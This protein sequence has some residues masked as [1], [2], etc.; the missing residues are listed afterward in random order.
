MGGPRVLEV[1]LRLDISEKRKLCGRIIISLW[2]FLWHLPSR[3]QDANWSAISFLFILRRMSYSTFTVAACDSLCVHKSR[4]FVASRSTDISGDSLARS[5]STSPSDIPR[6]TAS[7]WHSSMSTK[8]LATFTLVRSDSCWWAM[9]RRLE[10]NIHLRRSRDANLAITS[11]GEYSSTAV[12]RM[13]AE[14]GLG[15]ESSSTE[16]FTE[17]QAGGEK[18]HMSLTSLPCD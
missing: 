4:I 2:N 9:V 14:K 10:I 12:G 8:S 16:K 6:F 15:K 5:R 11:T 3:S 1:H 13:S 7:V 17:R 18:M